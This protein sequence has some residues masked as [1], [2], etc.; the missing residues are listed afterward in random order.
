M[1]ND[2]LAGYVVNLHHIIGKCRENIIFIHTRHSSIKYN[3]QFS[4]ITTFI[5]IDF[6]PQTVQWAR[7]SLIYV[8]KISALQ[9]KQ[10]YEHPHSVISIELFLENVFKLPLFTVRKKFNCYLRP[11]STMIRRTGGKK[12]KKTTFS[13]KWQKPGGRAVATGGSCGG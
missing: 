5:F 2:F 12:S 10:K 7:S 9:I 13:K 1:Q 8:I 3:A 6:F 11:F 4:P